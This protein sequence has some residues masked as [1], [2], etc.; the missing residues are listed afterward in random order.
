[1]LSDK[2]SEF[3]SEEVTGWRPRT[4]TMVGT[5]VLLGDSTS[6]KVFNLDPTISSDDG[7]V[8]ERAVS[9]V[10]AFDGGRRRNDSLEVWTGSS[11]DL[12]LRI[13]WHDGPETAFTDYWTA[14]SHYPQDIVRFTRLGA[15]RQPLRTIEISTIHEG[16]LRISRAT[17]NAGR[18]A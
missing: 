17:A 8:F 12:D 11:E 4:S 3:D 18:E 16:Q 6:G 7:V 10:V 1:M 5:T 14:T 2:W 15:A 9:G 13:R